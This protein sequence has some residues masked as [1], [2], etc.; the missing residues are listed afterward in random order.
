MVPAARRRVAADQRDRAVV[1][2]AR[3]ARR[4]SRVRSRQITP[5]SRSAVEL[6]VDDA[7]QLVRAPRRCAR[8]AAARPSA[9]D[10]LARRGAGTAPAGASGR[11]PGRRRSRG[12]RAATC[13]GRRRCRPRCT[14]SRPAR[15]ARRSAPRSRRASSVAVHSATMP[16]I[17]SPCAARSASFVKRGSSSRSG[18]SIALHS[19]EKLASEPATMHTYL[20]SR[21]R[22]VVERR[23]V[24]EPVALAAAHDAEP[25]VRGERPLEDAQRRRRRARRRSPRR[26]RRARRARTARATAA[27]AANTPV[28]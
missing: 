11:R 14:R 22:V 26:R 28:R 12:R 23:R 10:R 4:R 25:V 13:A 8:R 18:R 2:R 7:E 16:L 6:G 17:S 3:T 24:G 1:V 20:P 5:C 15:R 21:G 27:C 9:A 19:R